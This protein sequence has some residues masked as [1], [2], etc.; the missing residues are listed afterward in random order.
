MRLRSAC[1]FFALLCLA[2]VATAQIPAPACGDLHVVPAVRDCAAAWD[3]PIGEAG[4][5][6]SSDKDSHDAAEFAIQDLDESLK[7]R[8]VKVV[9]QGGAAT[10]GFFVASSA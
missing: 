5:L 7:A 6:V 8:G 10:I 4:V 3:I 1:S 2:F 9:N